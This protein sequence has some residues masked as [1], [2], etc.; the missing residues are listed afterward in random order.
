MFSL[1]LAVLLE[2]MGKAWKGHIITGEIEGL[3]T[4]RQAKPLL[5][6][7]ATLFRQRED[8][9]YTSRLITEPVVAPFKMFAR[10]KNRY[11]KGFYGGR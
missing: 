1:L 8:T 9:N 4:G 5:R 6:D 3:L 7:F 11:T 2:E 10:K